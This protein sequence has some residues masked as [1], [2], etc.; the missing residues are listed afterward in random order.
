MAPSRKP[1]NV[2]D[3][4]WYY[5]NKGSIE[6]I[7]IPGKLKPEERPLGDGI[8]VRIPKR[9]LKKSLGRMK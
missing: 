6:I 7:I 4:L 1:Q 2:S 9:M 3:A 8:Q 5:E